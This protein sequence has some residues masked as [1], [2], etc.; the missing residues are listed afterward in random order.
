M[1]GL[2]LFTHSVRMVF[3][4]LKEVVQIFL[5]PTLLT[6]GCIAAAG[7]SLGINP[8][9]LLS[10]AKI[11]ILN[12]GGGQFLLF[13]LFLLLFAFL[14]LWTAVAW[15]RFILLDERPKG[16]IPPLKINQM[17]RYLGLSLLITLILILPALVLLSIGGFVAVALFQSFGIWAFVGINVLLSTIGMTA[18]LCLSPVLPEAAIGGKPHINDAILATSGAVGAIFICAALPT[19]FSQAFYYLPLLVAKVS[20]PFAVGIQHAANLLVGMVSLSIMT[21]I[22]GH[23]VEG[24]ELS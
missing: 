4:N 5:V 3:G 16:F 7:L 22:Y 15:H 2:K 17:V 14:A 13:F 6:I 1:K 12:P 11:N 24:R 8:K 20:I 9:L 18:F 21:T 19:L 10:G 23:Y